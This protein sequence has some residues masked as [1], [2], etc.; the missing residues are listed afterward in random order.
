ML[1]GRIDE[2]TL[3][4]DYKANKSDARPIIIEEYVWMGTIN[5]GKKVMDEKGE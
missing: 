4:G 2:I 1:I 5:E 3:F